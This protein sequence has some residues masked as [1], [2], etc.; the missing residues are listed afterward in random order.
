MRPLGERTFEVGDDK[1]LFPDQ[2]PEFRWLG[3]ELLAQVSDREVVGLGFRNPVTKHI[4]WEQLTNVAP[5]HTADRMF[6]IEGVEVRALIVAYGAQPVYL[7][8][9]HTRSLEPSTTDIEFFPA[10]LVERGV[11]YCAPLDQT[12]LYDAS[13]VIT[14]PTPDQADS[15]TTPHNTES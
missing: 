8:H 7:W 14:V 10:W 12:T 15:L 2:E 5:A 4:I 9:S 3:G 13:G 6:D 1:Y 11:I